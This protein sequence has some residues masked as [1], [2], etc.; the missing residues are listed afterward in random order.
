MLARMVVASKPLSRNG[1]PVSRH[2]KRERPKVEDEYD[3]AKRKHK[4]KQLFRWVVVELYRA[5]SI[6]LSDPESGDEIYDPALGGVIALWKPSSTTASSS[7]A[8]PGSQ[9]LSREGHCPG[10]ESDVS[11]APPGEEAYVPLTPC[12]LAGPVRW[13]LST[14]ASMRVAKEGATTDEIT[15]FL[16]RR[17]GR[18]ERVGEWAVKDALKWLGE[19]G[20]VSHMSDGAWKLTNA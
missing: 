6:V 4:M 13:A 16:R 15:R 5:G 17:D 2:T 11:D 14:L 12:Y 8:S 1:K 19:K 10:L 9:S 18:W 3:R 7:L 20:L